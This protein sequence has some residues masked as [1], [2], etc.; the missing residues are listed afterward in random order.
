MIVSCNVCDH[1]R[2]HSDRPPAAKGAHS[3]IPPHNTARGIPLVTTTAQCLIRVDTQH[4]L[5]TFKF[6]LR[7]ITHCNGYCV[8]GRVRAIGCQH[9]IANACLS[10]TQFARAQINTTVSNSVAYLYRLIKFKVHPTMHGLYN[11]LI[12]RFV[13]N[14]RWPGCVML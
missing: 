8:I 9:D 2:C 13:F 5:I 3:T 11:G 4:G 7:V 1:T 14:N 6:Y 10:A 12:Q